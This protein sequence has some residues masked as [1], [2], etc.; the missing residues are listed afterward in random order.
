M[1]QST[2][3]QSGRVPTSLGLKVVGPGLQNVEA[4]GSGNLVG[5][6]EKTGRILGTAVIL[7]AVGL[8][9]TS[10]SAAS[11]ARPSANI[12]SPFRGTVILSDVVDK[13][14]CGAKAKLPVKP[15][16]SLSTGRGQALKGTASAAVCS[17]FTT[18]SAEV[19]GGFETLINLTVP[20]G[21]TEVYLN[22]SFSLNG[23]MALTPGTCK[24]TGNP[25]Y[26][27]CGSETLYDVTGTAYLF[28]VSA[29]Q[30][31]Y[32]GLIL[33]ATNYVLNWTQWNGASSGTHASYGATGTPGPFSASGAIAKSSV[34]S[35]KLTPGQKYEIILNIDATLLSEVYVE[36]SFGHVTY[37]GASA[38][39]SVNMATL[40]KGFMLASIGLS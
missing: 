15:T 16:F 31:T 33:N 38:V 13:S 9:L 36:N 20:R 29:G 18:D 35:A 17:G 11:A 24:I 7:A 6:G 37:T 39:T 19:S 12:I 8:L 40:G 4:M 14:G 26:A 1:K 10:S 21:T 25:T 22:G 2:L 32:L 27:L 34:L 30:Q 28:D 3:Y 5:R 23:S